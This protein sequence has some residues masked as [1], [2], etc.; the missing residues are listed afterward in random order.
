M[1]QLRDAVGQAGASERAAE[2]ILNA[3]ASSRAP[4]AAAALPSRRAGGQ[5]YN[6]VQCSNQSTALPRTAAVVFFAEP[7]RTSYD[8]NFRLFGVPVRVHP[9]F[10]LAMLLLGTNSETTPKEALVW[11][12]AAFVS[13]LVHEFGHVAA[14]TYFGSRCHVV[15]HGFGGLAI[16][17]F[18]RRAY[19]AA[20]N[21]D[22]AGRS[23]RR[24]SA[25]PGSS[26]SPFV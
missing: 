23:G 17:D 22:L 8:L 12:V 15:L 20:A 26:C 2:Y 24:V 18:N 6:S 7:Q 25:W 4:R 13:I 3:R 10:W 9:F 14:I 1:A 16:D 21:L 19:A 5:G 11:V